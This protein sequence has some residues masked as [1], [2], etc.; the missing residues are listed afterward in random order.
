MDSKL[1]SWMLAPRSLGGE[2][3]RDRGIDPPTA[4]LI[5]PPAGGSIRITPN[6]GPP[7]CSASASRRIAPQ[8]R[9]AGTVPVR[10]LSPPLKIKDTH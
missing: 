4:I 3:E 8:S 10:L 1:Q 7:L 5:S 9:K 2:V 6:A